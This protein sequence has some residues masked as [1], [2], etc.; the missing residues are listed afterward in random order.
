MRSL[1]E[2][3]EFIEWLPKLRI[4]YVIDSLAVA[5]PSRGVDDPHFLKVLDHLRD[6]ED[7]WVNLY[8]IYRLS[9][10][11]GPDYSDMIPIVA[12]LIEARPDRVVWGSNWPHAITDETPDDGDLVDF[13][14][15]A[16][17]DPRHQQ[18]VLVD[19]PAKLYG[20]AD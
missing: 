6:A 7:C 3:A 16:I 9:E 17:P 13:I 19:N 12:A 5:R 18:L 15:A 8:G 4:P 2:S 10:E 1:E 11:G 14:P 20:W